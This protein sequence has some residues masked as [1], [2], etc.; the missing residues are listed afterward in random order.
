MLACLRVYEYTCILKLIKKIYLQIN[1]M[2]ISIKGCLFYYFLLILYV[3]VE[4]SKSNFY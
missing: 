4:H 3:E 1:D 2:L